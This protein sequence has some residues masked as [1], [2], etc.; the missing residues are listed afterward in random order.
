MGHCHKRETDVSDFSECEVTNISLRFKTFFPIFFMHFYIFKT[1]TGVRRSTKLR[2]FFAET[3]K[4]V[5]FLRYFYY[6]GIGKST[7]IEISTDVK[8]PTCITLNYL[9]QS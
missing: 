3:S 7:R 5:V 8:T 9:L 2:K 1:C 4:K 6:A